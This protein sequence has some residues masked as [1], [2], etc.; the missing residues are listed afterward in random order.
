MG[1]ADQ[2]VLEEPRAGAPPTPDEPQGQTADPGR[3]PRRPPVLQRPW[4]RAREGP[5]P[6][7]S[8]PKALTARMA[9]AQ[10]A[11]PGDRTT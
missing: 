3:R 11:G 10:A 2:A 8:W 4:A 9:S 1:P 7:S 5:P 6:T